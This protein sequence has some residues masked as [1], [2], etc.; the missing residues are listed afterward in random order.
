MDDEE[1]YNTLIDS[2][3]AIDNALQDDNVDALDEASNQFLDGVQTQMKRDGV[4]V[5]LLR[6]LASTIADLIE[7]ASG[8][9]DDNTD[10]PDEDSIE[11]K[12][13]D[14]VPT[15]ESKATDDGSPENSTVLLDMSE[16]KS[17]TDYLN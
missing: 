12:D 10:A 8:E 14:E 6:D 7:Q 13:E 3:N 2:A 9:G 15:D 4:N 1:V 11:K 16:F 5:Q 17:I